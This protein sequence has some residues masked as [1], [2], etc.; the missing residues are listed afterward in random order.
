MLPMAAGG[1]FF[2]N[3]VRTVPTLPW[4]RVTCTHAHAAAA[5]STQGS[6]KGAKR[7]VRAANQPAERAAGA[8]CRARMLVAAAVDGCCSRLLRCFTQLHSQAA[9]YQLLPLHAINCQLR[10]ADCRGAMLQHPRVAVAAR[11]HGAALPLPCSSSSIGRASR[12]A[13]IH[14]STRTS[15]QPRAAHA[16]RTLPQIT[17]YLLPFF[18]VLALYTYATLRQQQRTRT[19]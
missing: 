4:A 9:R 14:G 1:R 6:A 3:L 2:W 5:S 17:R 15:A 16:A 13:A 12:R 7:A 10:H 11:Q 19:T 18:S 8:A